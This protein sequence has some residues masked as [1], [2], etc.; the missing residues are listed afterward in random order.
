MRLRRLMCGKPLAFRE[1]SQP[2]SR[3][4]L[5]AHEAQPQTTKSVTERQSLS[6]HQAA[7]PLYLRIP[8]VGNF[9]FAVLVAVFAM[10]Y[11]DVVTEA[12]SLR[13]LAARATLPARPSPDRC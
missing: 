9:F 11:T 4:C 6:A 8:I 1:A 2:A 3:L 10:A 12:A 13:E 7:K 5:E